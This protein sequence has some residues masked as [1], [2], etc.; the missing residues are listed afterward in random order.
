MPS[1]SKWSPVII[2]ICLCSIAY[3]SPD[4]V[5]IAICNSVKHALRN[6]I[7]FSFPPGL[8]W[9]LS[10]GPLVSVLSGRSYREGARFFHIVSVKVSVRSN[11][12]GHLWF[13]A[14]VDIGGGP[15]EFL[16]ESCW[17][18]LCAATL[19][20]DL[21]EKSKNGVLSNISSSGSV[22]FNLWRIFGE[23][24][25][26]LVPTSE[27]IIFLISSRARSVQ[28]TR[29]S[30]NGDLLGFLLLILQNLLV[31][32]WSHHF[33]SNFSEGFTCSSG[34]IWWRFSQGK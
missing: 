27:D 1:I 20:C 32:G 11:E 13:S 34:S 24:S 25:K 10:P 3:C 26:M 14:W 5:H 19:R 31:I 28:K 16:E 2:C 4:W 29:T 18:W 23:W 9:S 15:V 12:K 8:V 22:S 21:K 6:R 7:L 30:G 33:Y 17:Q